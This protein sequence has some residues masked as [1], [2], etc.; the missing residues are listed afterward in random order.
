[1]NTRRGLFRLWIFASAIWLILWSAYVWVSR[2]DAMEDTTGR[3]FVAFH[4]GFGNG[5]TE[6]KDF[7][8]GD[9]L[10]L[11]SVGFGLPL[12]FLGFGYGVAWIVAGFS[13]SPK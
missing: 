3:S 5:W 1:M 9:C 4:T 11:A 6:L 7:T 2:L 13:R 8:L 10:S 12:A